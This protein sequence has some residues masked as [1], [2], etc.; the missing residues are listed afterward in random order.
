MLSDY[1]CLAPMLS[2]SLFLSLFVKCGLSDKC[3]AHWCP[4]SVNYVTIHPWVGIVFCY[5]HS[6]KKYRKRKEKEKVRER[7]S[8]REPDNNPG[9]VCILSWA[10]RLCQSSGC[11]QGE[12]LGFVLSSPRSAIAVCLVGKLAWLYKKWLVLFHTPFLLFPSLSLSYLSL[13]F[14]HIYCHTS[15]DINLTQTHQQTGKLWSI[16]YHKVWCCLSL[17]LIDCGLGLSCKMKG[18]G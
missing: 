10:W 7:E 5:P 17:H 12:G 11:I 2:L 8:G 14:S 13:A 1:L 3:L 15:S 9:W 16:W 18:Q 6:R 4:A